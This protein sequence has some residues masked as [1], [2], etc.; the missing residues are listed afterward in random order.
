MPNKGYDIYIYNALVCVH[1]TKSIHKRTSAIFIPIF[2]FWLPSTRF[3]HQTIS[4]VHTFEYAYA[5]CTYKPCLSN[6][7]CSG[8]PTTLWFCKKM[9]SHLLRF[10]HKR[11]YE[12]VFETWPNTKHVT[13]IILSSTKELSHS[14][15][16][17]HITQQT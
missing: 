8:K 3:L 17:S 16:G 9:V 11:K 5:T 7:I 4:L 12:D 2:I 13:L 10:L 15:C 14:L 6:T 1:F